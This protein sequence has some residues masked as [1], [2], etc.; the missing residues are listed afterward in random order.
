[1]RGARV[2]FTL[3]IMLGA[4]VPARA[5]RADGKLRA[6]IAADNGRLMAA[7]QAGDARDMASVY[8]PRGVIFPPNA[9][10]AS[11]RDAIQAFWDGAIHAGIT[12]MLLQTTELEQ[13]GDALLETGTYTFL[14][15]QGQTLDLGKYLVVWVKENGNWRIYRAMW[16]GSMPAPRR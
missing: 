7:V 6:T 8:S 12:R 16:N 11:G 15:G 2:A 14:G 13:R 4:A 10:A 3:G 9:S 1:M 5:Q